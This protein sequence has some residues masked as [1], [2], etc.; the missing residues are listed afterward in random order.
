MQQCNLLLLVCGKRVSPGLLDHMKS[1]FAML[2]WG[3]GGNIPAI[4]I[5]YYNVLVAVQIVCNVVAKSEDGRII[6]S[7]PSR[8]FYYKLL[9]RKIW[10]CKCL[11]PWCFSALFGV[12]MLE[13]NRNTCPINIQ[14][15]HT[16]QHS[17]KISIYAHCHTH[18]HL[19]TNLYPLLQHLST[20][21]RY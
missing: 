4:T 18:P 20:C 7:G 11:A 3:G 14:H 10:P 9:G 17:L 19:Q 2:A 21:Y 6:H 1:L 8:N 5:V 12:L 16:P 13:I 15:Y